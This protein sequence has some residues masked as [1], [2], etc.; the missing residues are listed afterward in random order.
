[1]QRQALDQLNKAQALVDLSHQNH[2]RAHQLRAIEQGRAIQQLQQAEAQLAQAYQL[3]EEEKAKIPRDCDQLYQL[4]E[5]YMAQ[6]T[7]AHLLRQA[8]FQ[9]YQQQ[10]QKQVESSEWIPACQALDKT[11]QSQQAQAQQAQSQQAQAQQAQSQQAQDE[12]VPAQG[13]QAQGQQAQSQQAQDEQVPAQEGS[14]ETGS[15]TKWLCDG[16]QQSCKNRE[17]LR[18][19]NKTCRF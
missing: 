2:S 4:Y 18:K 1:M 15:R 8:Q 7:Q 11:A 12:Q 10:Y 5:A 13:Q 9:Q 17:S 14:S 3:I 19:H 16:C 6:L